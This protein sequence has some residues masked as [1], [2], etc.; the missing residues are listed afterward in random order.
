M[1]LN[2]RAPGMGS[3]EWAG[4]YWHVV[5]LVWIVLFAILCLV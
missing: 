5:D 1:V 2:L 4:L 3:I